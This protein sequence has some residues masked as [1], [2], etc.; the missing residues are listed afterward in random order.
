MFHSTLSSTICG[1]ITCS[2]VIFPAE[3]P[4]SVYLKRLCC[5]ISSKIHRYFTACYTCGNHS[6]KMYAFSE[7]EE[8]KFEI[9]ML[10]ALISGAV[11]LLLSLFFLN[12][13]L[14]KCL[15]K[16]QTNTIK[17][18]NRRRYVSL[19]STYS[20]L[21]SH[22]SLLGYWAQS[23]MGHHSDTGYQQAGTHFANLRRM[24][25]SQLHLVLIQQ[26]SGI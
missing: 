21:W 9:A 10:I 22:F 26:P 18:I 11:I 16:Y 19:K 24:T 3:P 23:W 2:E 12:C 4:A 5:K 17:G 20:T 8:K 7:N 14:N 6:I 25:S 1:S 13:C 15:K